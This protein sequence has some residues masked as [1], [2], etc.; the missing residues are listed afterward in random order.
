MNPSVQ[1]RIEQLRRDIRHHDRLYYIENNPAI[2]D[3]EYDRLFA[4]LKQLE[5]QH[6]ELITPDSPTQRVAGEPL[7]AF[8]TVPHSRPMLSMDNTYSPDELRQF[9]Q[10]VRKT[11]ADQPFAYAVEEKI[12]GVAVSLR[13]ENGAL[14]LGATR[15]DGRRGDDITTN[16]RT[17]QSVPLRLESL[18]SGSS[19]ASLFENT[20]PEVLEVR[21]EVFMPNSEFLRLNLQRQQNDDPPFANP[22]NATAG[23]LKLLDSRI[24]ASRK[25]RFLA[26]AL[27]EVR[28]PEFAAGHLEML[29]KLRSLS[30]PVSPHV[31]KA[32]DIEKV[33]NLCAKW[34]QKR[35]DLDYQIDGMVIKV[36][37]LD[38]QLRLGRTSRAPR[39]CIAYKFA[40]EQ[41]ETVV[42]KI[43]VQVGKT[44]A[45]TPVANLT[46]VHLAGTTVSRASL[47]NFDEVARLDVREGDTVLVEKAGEIIPQVVRVLTEK[48]PAP[49]RPFPVPTKC[50]NC[51]HAVRKEENGVYIRC[52]NPAC[53]A[54]LVERLRYFAGRNQMD[55]DGLGIALIEQLVEQGLV[56]SFA[57][58]YRLQKVQLAALERMGD[59]SADNLITALETGKNRPLDRVLAALGILH[60]GSRAAQVLAE[61]LGS[62]QALLEADTARLEQIDEIGPV[63]AESIHRFC[64][65]KHTRALIEDLLKVG[66]KMPG[67][68]KPVAS[69]GPLT[70]KTIV[71]TGSVEGFTRTQLQ[72][73]IKDHG[74]RP[75]SAVS[76]KT[77]L[78][79]YGDSPG[80]KLDKAQKLGVPVLPA[81]EF[82]KMVKNE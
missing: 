27:G 19:S 17:I 36:D 74:G 72:Q 81:E 24:V 51:H 59:K 82:L 50:P 47:H 64:H 4:E 20:V 2:G 38:Q 35:H 10:R 8:T 48:R 11:L 63:M 26:Y 61:A 18:E 44:G 78:V 60:V 49:S 56:K 32:A 29:D 9:D 28:P 62:I 54:Q 41:A 67:P 15:G 13:Y 12:D 57:D 34:E 6:P 68:P 69:E 55:I 66:L 23:S 25:L 43:T 71:V 39:W 79:I 46:P 16:I 5:Q 21:G 76:A 30:L 80:S 77:D 42:E 65:E 73:M 31:R 45:L 52:L 53:S 33:I 7:D 40:A 58:L 1:K 3:R 70:G 22:R 14:V 75:A 37:R